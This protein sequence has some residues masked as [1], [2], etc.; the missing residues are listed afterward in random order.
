[1]D[2]TPAPAAKTSD[3][4]TGILRG[5]I[6]A[7][8]AETTGWQLERD[9]GTRIDVDVTKVADAAAGLDRQ[10]V[11]IDGSI[12]T[13]N[14]VERGEKQLLLAERIEPAPGQK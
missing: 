5:G 3:R 10:R 12:V 7:I 4:F 6:V 11:V 14:W 2:T 8:G 1:M 13:A 9:D